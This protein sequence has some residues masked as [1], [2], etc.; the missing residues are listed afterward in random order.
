MKFSI[1][2]VVKNNKKKIS[3]TINSVLS[4]NNKNYEYLIIDGQSTDGTSEVIKKIKKNKYVKLKHVIKKDKNLY[5]ALNRG[6][7]ISKGQFI[8]ILHSG[9][10]FYNNNILDFVEHNIK[11]YDLCFGNII[12][13]KNK[14]ITRLWNYKVKKFN[15][16]NAFKVA[17]TSLVVKTNLIKKIKL[18]DEKYDI[19]SDTDFILRLSII[20]N[21]KYKYLNKYLIVMESGGLSSS[22]NNFFKKMMED[23]KIYYKYFKYN[24]IFFYIYKIIYKIY[25]L[26]I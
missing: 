7:K 23:L 9:D 15:K 3:R 14:E 4:Q 1:I 26:A 16:F 17:H 5:E 24:F 13:K 11:N 2:T 20:K 25:R 22:Y 21:L 6:V 19:S 8:I 10:I 12:I 18:Y